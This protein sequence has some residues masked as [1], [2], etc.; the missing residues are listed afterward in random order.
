MSEEGK[1]RFDYVK[2]NTLEELKEYVQ[3]GNL[4]LYADKDE[5]LYCFDWYFRRTVRFDKEAYKWVIDKRKT[6]DEFKDMEKLGKEEFNKII[7]AI[8]PFDAFREYETLEANKTIE[9]YN[10]LRKQTD[11]KV[12]GWVSKTKG[13]RPAND[14]NELYSAAILNDIIEHKYFFVADW[15]QLI[16]VFEDKKYLDLSSRAM[17]FLIALSRGEADDFSYVDYAFGEPFFFEEDDFFNKPQEGLYKD[18]K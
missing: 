7:Q 9:Y 2:F 1:I 12:I 6:F 17:G 16:P 13:Y 4:T 3:T 18:E 11:K 10:N 8:P 15:N 14:K 5:V